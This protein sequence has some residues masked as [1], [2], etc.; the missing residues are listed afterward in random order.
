MN[1]AGKT[2]PAID[3]NGPLGRLDG[4]WV[5]D[6]LPRHL[7]ESLAPNDLAT[8]HGTEAILLAVAA[9]PDPVPEEVGGVESNQRGAVPAVL[10]G[11]MVGQ[12]DCAM[13]VG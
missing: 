7:G 13:A 4:L 11:V 3:Q 5:L 8:L 2:I 1:L 9:V 6:R 12:V 10:R